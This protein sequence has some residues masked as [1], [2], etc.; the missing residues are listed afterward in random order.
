MWQQRLGVFGVEGRDKDRLQHAV[1]APEIKLAFVKQRCVEG[2][3]KV[4][5]VDGTAG[6][7]WTL[8]MTGS[9][10]DIRITHCT[11]TS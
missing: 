3:P 2:L 6:Y 4:L 5:Q 7:T 8:M 11:Y 1:K 10:S 9:M